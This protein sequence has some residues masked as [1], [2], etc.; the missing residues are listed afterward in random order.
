MVSTRSQSKN[1]QNLSNENFETSNEDENVI[2]YKIFGNDWKCRGYQYK[3]GEEAIMNEEPELCIRGFHFC[4]KPVNCLDY[5]DVTPDSNH[6]FAKVIAKGVVKHSENN[7]K[8][9]TNRL[10]VQKKISKK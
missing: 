7:H 9:V 10:Y 5:Y 4:T 1:I 3:V 6:Q 2:G 8:S